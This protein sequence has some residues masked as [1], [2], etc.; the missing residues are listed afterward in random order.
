MALPVRKI[1][2][3][4]RSVTGKVPEIGSYEST[5]ERDLMEILRFDRH[6]E[7]VSPQPLV[8]DYINKKGDDSTYTPD[9]LITFIPSLAES[10]ILYEVKYRE[11][12]RKEWRIY[13]EKFRAA[14]AFC[15]DRYW[16]FRVYTEYEIRTPYLQN[17]KF[18]WRYL[19]RPIEDG[20]RDL[21]LDAMADL[22]TADPELLL[23]TL[24]NDAT[25]RA[26]AVPRLWHLVASGEI[27]C[28]LDEK[29]TMRSKI[30]NVKDI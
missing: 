3:N 22:Q 13:L 12:F 7:Q 17:V 18:L 20:W 16:Q 8:I 25:N 24:F 15:R 6:I 27:G 5:L 26:L 21:I 11:D 4:H 14:K 19:Q 29:L 23:L 9:G 1:R 28:N 2:A 30:W 10:P